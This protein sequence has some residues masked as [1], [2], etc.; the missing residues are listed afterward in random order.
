MYM[1]IYMYMYMYMHVH[2]CILYL[3][4]TPSHT[5][6]R[7]YVCFALFLSLSCKMF[8]QPAECIMTCDMAE[9]LLQDSEVDSS[10]SGEEHRERHCV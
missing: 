6:V 9:Y 1:C 7:V 2:D 5:R 8:P 3:A 4:L 10:L